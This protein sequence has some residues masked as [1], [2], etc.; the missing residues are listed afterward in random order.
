MDNDQQTLVNLIMYLLRETRD[1]D[2]FVDALRE[3]NL[4]K[5]ESEYDIY[6]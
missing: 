6:D 4:M 2:D 3:I 5:E 1:E